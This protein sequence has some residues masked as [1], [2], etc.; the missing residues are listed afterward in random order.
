MLDY[1][2]FIYIF[3]FLII[4]PLLIFV[5]YF[6][7]KVDPKIFDALV[8]LGGIIIVYHLYKL[9]NVQLIKRNYITI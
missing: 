2:D 5:G 7:E 1:Y 8:V 3:H 4:G 6:K 9:I